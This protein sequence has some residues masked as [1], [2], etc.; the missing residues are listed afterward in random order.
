MDCQ[1]ARIGFRYGYVTALVTFFGGISV[2]F[3]AGAQTSGSVA[4]EVLSVQAGFG[5]SWDSNLFRRPDFVGPRSEVLTVTSGTLR[6]DKPVSRQ[7]FQLELNEDMK[8]YQN[9]SYLD[10]NATRYRA[11][12]LWNPGNWLNASLVLDRS[13]S[14]APF[15]DT[16]TNLRNVSI[17]A[18]KV[19][20]LNGRITGGWN[21]L[22]NLSRT[23][24]KSELAIAVSP[25]QRMDSTS[26]GFRYLFPSGNYLD[27]KQ[28]ASRGDYLNQSIIPGVS[29]T[30]FKESASEFSAYWKVGGR[31][32]LTGHVS[33]TR[34]KDGQYTQRDFSGA[35]GDITYGWKPTA[36]LGLSLTVSRSL[37]PLQ[38]PSFSYT[39]NNLAS[40]TSTWQIS[41]KLA[42]HLLVSRTTS[43][44]RGQGTTPAIEMARRDTT[45]NTEAGVDWLPIRALTIRLSLQ[46]Q[47][48]DSNLAMAKYGDK[49]AKIDATWSF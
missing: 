17:R 36:K 34:R 44:Y 40:I 29:G 3:D 32:D 47:V 42:A 26:I 6:F 7:R 35:S 38:T 8:R 33:L 22:A 37:Q 13:R 4:N 5:Q 18:N 11:S 21:W 31:S 9:F 19:L 28:R 41:S 1:I 2:T 30:S 12:W 46:R 23:D 24:Q 14:L 39:E 45:T 48:R 27:F 20:D 15:E 16:L 43:G 25:S 10:F 49:V